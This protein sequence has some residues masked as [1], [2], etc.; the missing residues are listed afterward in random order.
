MA[1]AIV[2]FGM[3]ADVRFYGE[4]ALGGGDEHTYALFPNALTKVQLIRCGLFFHHFPAVRPH[5]DR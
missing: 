1:S 5:G 2:L 4:S 3:S